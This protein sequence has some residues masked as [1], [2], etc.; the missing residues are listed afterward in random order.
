MNAAENVAQLPVAQPARFTLAP[1]NYD[2][3]V[4]F[5]KTIAASE[6]VPKDYRDKPENVFVAI[7]FG[8]EIGLPPLQAVQNIA[9]INGRPGLWGDAVWAIVKSNPAC[10][11]T[12]ETFD[13]HAMTATC[14]IKRRGNAA[15]TVTFSKA[16]AEKAGLWG[17]Q[18]PW[19]TAPKRMLQMRARAFC[20]RDVFPDA[21]KGMGVAEELQD[22]PEKDVTPHGT[23]PAA[24]AG[25]PVYAQ[26]DFDKNLPQWTKLIQTGIKSADDIITMVSTKGTLTDEQK[27]KLQAIK[28]PIDA[29]PEP[30]KSAAQNAPAVDPVKLRAR[31]ES[32]ADL[33]LL[34]AEA[35]LINQVAD[36][37]AREELTEVYQTRREVLEGGAK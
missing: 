13:A 19:Q 26:A 27:N 34:A 5:A 20:A 22:I 25:P 36:V 28:P 23:A 2:E 21:L 12:S 30:P 31:L 29:T 9:V 18:G 24:P 4:K 3:A 1:S 33:D 17:K 16:D 37:G 32:A 8:A 11:S 14:T 7:C 15:H 6:L 10:E 35:D